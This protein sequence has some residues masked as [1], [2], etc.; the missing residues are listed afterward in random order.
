MSNEFNFFF[1]FTL[2][3]EQCTELRQESE[4]PEMMQDQNRNIK[5]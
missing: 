2:L 1:R 3:Q 4:V 5:L